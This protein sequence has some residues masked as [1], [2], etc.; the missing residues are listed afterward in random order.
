MATAKQ[1]SLPS[2]SPL[3]PSDAR[4]QAEARAMRRE[5]TELSLMSGS[6]RV[7]GSVRF[8]ERVRQPTHQTIEL[9]AA[10][11]LDAAFEEYSRVDVGACHVEAPRGSATL[12]GDARTMTKSLVADIAVQLD[13]LDRQREQL[14]AL[15]RDVDT[16]GIGRS[17]SR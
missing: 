16:S 14:A 2:L 1:L 15:L 13:I 9:P 5:P 12:A 10:D 8:G 7:R 17:P 4:Q 11:V 6:T 3:A